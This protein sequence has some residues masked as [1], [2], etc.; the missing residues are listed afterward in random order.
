MRIDER[1][2]GGVTILSVSGRVTSREN[3]ALLK[4]TITSAVQ[5]RHP[6]VALDLQRVSCIVS[7]GLGAIVGGHTIVSGQGGRLML[8]N[9]GKCLRDLFRVMKLEIVL[10]FVDSEQEAVQS[11]STE[12]VARTRHAVL[13]VPANVQDGGSRW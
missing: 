13:L 4:D 11:V 10:E 6:D 5:R 9:V 7:W 8:L 1:V 3:A 2:V 12:T